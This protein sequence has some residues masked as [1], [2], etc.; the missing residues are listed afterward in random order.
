M[1]IEGRI[2]DDEG[3]PVKDAQVSVLQ[4][5]TSRNEDLNPWAEALKGAKEA[6]APESRFLGKRACPNLLGNILPPR[7][8]GA[9]GHFVLKGVGNERI[10]TLRVE[11]PDIATSIINVATRP[12]DRVEMPDYREA[13]PPWE[14]RSTMEP[15]LNTAYS[16]AKPIVGVVRDKDYG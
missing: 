9:N 1:P 4:I 13:H 12:L 10:A 16:T 3:R 15:R 6:R 11:G 14:N 8:T 2:V 7:K 5:G